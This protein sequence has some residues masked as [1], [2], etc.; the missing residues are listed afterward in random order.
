[1]SLTVG[2]LINFPALLRVDREGEQGARVDAGVR[3]RR[4]AH[5]LVQPRLRPRHVPE[6]GRLHHGRHDP[7][8]EA[9][10]RLSL[11]SSL[12]TMAASDTGNGAA[13][14]AGCRDVGNAWKNISIFV[15][16]RSGSMHHCLVS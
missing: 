12:G 1:M 15:W 11:P 4:G 6:G 10:D 2:V 14:D 13:A 16:I 5:R 8:Q 3:P 9:R 7:R